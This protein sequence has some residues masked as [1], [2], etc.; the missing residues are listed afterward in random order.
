M[1]W[2]DGRERWY[3]YNKYHRAYGPACT[4][5]EGN[6]EWWYHGVK[7]TCNEN[8]VRE[9]RRITYNISSLRTQLPIESHG[10]QFP[11]ELLIANYLIGI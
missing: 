3:I 8:Y 9:V 5:E 10:V 1:T 2:T 6:Q 7:E 4:D 11:F